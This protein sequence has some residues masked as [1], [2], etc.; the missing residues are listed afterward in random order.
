MTAQ[1]ADAA[2][3]QGKPTQS[4]DAMHA[5]TKNAIDPSTV[6]AYAPMRLFPMELPTSQAA[7]SPNVK[8][9]MDATATG[10]AKN[11]N[12]IKEPITQYVPDW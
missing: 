2:I 5:T 7:P 1:T 4:D 8:I 3:A 9:R 12:A 10:S 6:L 11:V